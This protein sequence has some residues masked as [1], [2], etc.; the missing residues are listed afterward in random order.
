MEKRNS[1]A[2][3][4]IKAFAI[5]FVAFA[6]CSYH[7]SELVG[8]ISGL[9]GSMGVPIFLISSGVFFNGEEKAES[10]WMKKLKGIVVPWAIF[11]VVTYIIKIV[12]EGGAGALDFLKWFVGYGCWLYF[13]P[14]LLVCY[15]IFRAIRH[16]W[17]PY[18]I[19]G[20][21]LLSN[22]LECFDLNPVTW[23]V[24][25]Y[26]N[27]FN[28]AGYFAIGIL[29][30]KFGVMHLEMPKM[31]VKLSLS[32]AC[33]TVGA[34][35]IVT[36][37]TVLSFLLSTACILLACAALFFWSQSL[38]ECRLLQSVGKQTYFIYFV[39][40]QLVIALVNKIVGFFGL[41]TAADW[42]LL[43]V[44]PMA[45][46]TITYVV[47]VAA[48]KVMELVKLDKYKWIIGLK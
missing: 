48:I 30:K 43:F 39:H 37:V 19:I 14:L 12:L 35:Y 28:R 21:F 13:V 6:H 34:L 3:Y 29:L 11:G 45:I 33:V 4:V 23:A 40:M 15:V 20:L 22:I 38:S 31:W 42:A 8:K 25:H 32:A 16:E 18:V 44:R 41:P 7:N 36:D 46:L 47:A 26:L 1:R 2:F 17:L 5:L 10:F 27:V 9:I 24:G